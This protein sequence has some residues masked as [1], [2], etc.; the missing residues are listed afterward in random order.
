MESSRA[1]RVLSLLVLVAAAAGQVPFLGSCPRPPIVGNF[2]PQFY[3]GRW[4]EYSKYFTVFEVG[5]KCIQAVYSDAGYGRIGVTNRSI[6]VLGGTRSDIRGVA[7]PV[8]RPGQAKLRVNFEGVPSF[9]SDANYIVLDTDYTQYAIVWSCS[10][11]KLFNTQ[12]LFV[13]TREQFPSPY[14]VKHIMKRIRH[15]GL[16][17]GKLQ[18][19]DQKNCPYG[20]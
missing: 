8:G 2:E 7:K 19:T 18:K 11:L 17:T 3:L 10:S 14:L 20:H 6:K 12:F 16:D 9:G 4:Y 1:L 15:F 13:L 5:R